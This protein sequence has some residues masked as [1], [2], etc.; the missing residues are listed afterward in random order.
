MAYY[1]SVLPNGIRIIH[2]ERRSKVSHCGI[3]IDAGARDE[4]PEESGLAHFIEHTLFKGTKKRKAYHILSRLENVGGELNAYTSKEETFVHASFLSDYYERALELLADILSN[5]TFPEKEIRKEIDVVIDEINSYKDSPSELIF[6]EF[7]ELLF[8][9]HPLGNS[10]LGKPETVRSFSREAIQRFIHRQYAPEHMVIATVGNISADRF[11]K[12]CLK[13]FGDYPFHGN[14]GLRTPFTG[15]QPH[16]KTDSKS[17][18]QVHCMLG[19]LA[20]PISSPRRITMSLL[21]NITGGPGMN[22]RLNMTVR[23][24]YGYCYTIESHFQPFSDAGYFAVYFGTDNGYLEKAIQVIFREFKRL[25]E[26]ALGTL[27]LHRAKRQLIGQLAMAYESGPAEMQ[28]IAKSC[29]YLHRADTFEEICL[30]IENITSGDL[31]EV[32]NEILVP[33]QFTR[34]TYLPVKNMDNG[35]S[36]IS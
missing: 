29:L 16:Q 21:N 6:D 33:E 23:E 15:Y 34:L 13:Y 9:G 25:R 17:N 14:G 5:P 18:Y 11:E 1:Q 19:T 31:L 20:Y 22:T 12:L 26:N 2:S 28:A 8:A 35:L 30:N 32:A 36:C 10:V 3:M 7:E 24:Q 4:L 27:Q